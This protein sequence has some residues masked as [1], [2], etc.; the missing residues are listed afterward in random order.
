MNV[1]QLGLCSHVFSAFKTVGGKS[2]FSHSPDF[3]LVCKIVQQG[4]VRAG[5]VGGDH[6]GKPSVF[7]QCGGL[8]ELSGKIYAN[9]WIID[10]IMC[11]IK[12][13]MR[14]KPLF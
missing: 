1:P 11:T 13:K 9:G 2:D 7:V 3:H 8:V 10:F 14:E 6:L 12:N 5:G 4:L